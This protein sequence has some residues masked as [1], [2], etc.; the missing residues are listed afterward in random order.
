MS[1]IDT[2]NGAEGI[3]QRSARRDAEDLDTGG[4]GALGLTAQACNTTYVMSS[5][6]SGSAP[7]AN[8]QASCPTRRQP[9]TP[10]ET[11]ATTSRSSTASSAGRDR[12]GECDVGI[13]HCSVACA[14]SLRCAAS[15]QAWSSV[16]TT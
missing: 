11:R 7:V 1:P 9:H 15:G 4:A 6:S 16:S 10:P 8:W 5:P 2:S 14:A 3:V 13:S 12:K